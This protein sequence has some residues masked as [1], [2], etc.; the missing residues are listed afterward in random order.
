MNR[1][2]GRLDR[3]EAGPKVLLDGRGDLEGDDVLNDD[4][5]GGDDADVGTLMGGGLGLKQD[6]GARGTGSEDGLQPPDASQ[7]DREGMP[8]VRQLRIP[9]GLLRSDDALGTDGEVD[10]PTTVG[11][12]TDEPGVLPPG[13]HQGVVNGASVGFQ[14]EIDGL[15][16]LP[17]TGV[18]ADGIRVHDM[19]CHRALLAASSV[20]GVHLVQFLSSLSNRS[21]G[22]L[23]HRPPPVQQLDVDSTN[24]IP[25]E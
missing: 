10:P 15:H 17:T 7:D 2:K 12:A 19:R 21:D 4:A 1:L 25:A 9:G 23:G 3:G 14:A 11:T 5:G 8:V 13:A 18:R 22:H 20:E 16:L 6:P 24:G